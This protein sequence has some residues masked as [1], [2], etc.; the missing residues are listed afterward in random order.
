[1]ARNTSGLKRDAGPGR[2]KGSKDRIPKSF[3]ASI[4]RAYEEL[5]N[6]DPNLYKDRIR[7]DVKSGRGSV[8][9]HH[10]QLAAYYLDGKPVETVKVNGV[11]AAPIVVVL[12]PE[13]PS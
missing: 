11:A 3:K 12:P 10:I 2:P 8:G 5:A 6:E 7:R 4:A 13:Q 9:F 1:V